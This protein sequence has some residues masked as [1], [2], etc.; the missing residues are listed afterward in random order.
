MTTTKYYEITEPGI[1]GVPMTDEFAYSYY[2]GY[3]LTVNGLKAGNLVEVWAQFQVNNPYIE[4]AAQVTAVICRG[5]PTGVLGEIPEAVSKCFP[6]SGADILPRGHFRM[7]CAAND[8]IVRAGS[9]T[10]SLAVQTATTFK[11]LPSGAALTFLAGYG[12]MAIKV[13]S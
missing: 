4:F 8:R 3:T 13:F 1:D 2:A 6:L 7:L 5:E 10:Y 11:P 9:R 12:G